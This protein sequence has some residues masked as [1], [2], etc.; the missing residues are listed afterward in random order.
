[1]EDVVKSHVKCLDKLIDHGADIGQV[2][3]NQH[4]TLCY[5]LTEGPEP[6]DMLKCL[7][8]CL[9]LDAKEVTKGFSQSKYGTFLI[10]T[11]Y[12]LPQH[13]KNSMSLLLAIEKGEAGL[14]YA[15]Q[16]LHHMSNPNII[17]YVNRRSALSYAC[18]YNPSLVADLMKKGAD[19]TQ[20]DVKSNSPVHFA[21]KSGSGNENYLHT[22]F[23]SNSVIH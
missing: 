4:D 20:Y 18:Q 14:G 6:E 16:I 3:N 19:A 8:L 21:A 2:D 22:I 23:E 1:M 12:H 5:C 13:Y 7:N 10:K 9:D 11:I 15:Q 17:N